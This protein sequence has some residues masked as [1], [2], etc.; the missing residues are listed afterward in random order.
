MKRFIKEPYRW[1]YF[2]SAGF[3]YLGCVLRSI[4]YYESV[5]LIQ[6]L[7]ILLI[8]LGLYVA[9]I[10]ITPNWHPF[11]YFYLFIQSVL[12]FV[13]TYIH[14]EPDF[15]CVLFAILGMQIMQAIKPG[16]GVFIIALFTPLT[17][18]S[19]TRV[20]GWDQILPLAFV[21]LA[22]NVLLSSYVY[23]AR[24]TTEA[25]A[26]NEHLMDELHSA[27]D[28]LQVYARELEQFSV[29]HERNRLP[30]ELHDSV[31]QTI[32][33]MTLTT[34]SARL[35]LKQDPSQVSV[36]LD[37]LNLLAH[38]AQKEMHQLISQ[39]TPMKNQRKSLAAQLKDHIDQQLIT[40]V[41]KVSMEVSGDK[42][43]KTNEE[44]SLFRIAQEAL[45]NII[46]HSHSKQATIRLHMDEPYW[47]DIE[48]QGQGF[49]P[50]HPAN[51]SGVGLASMR[52]R[53]EGIGWKFDIRS[54][55]NKG[56]IV[57]VEKRRRKRGSGN[58]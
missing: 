55:P 13:V 17:A 39:L 33:S 14:T 22:A 3:L 27:N 35:L 34:Q 26:R 32:F 58:G 42:V 56:T 4:I 5:D 30:R 53:A 19:L 47:M 37:R 6:V 38:N 24:R 20:Y 8:W 9:E 11:I 15:F 12:I 43:L 2:L 49:D 52:E 16:L 31:T 36:Q 18:L 23:L 44:Q 29:A 10:F 40:D 1:V 51:G 50:D 21:Y 48:D 41:I 45:N 28:Q 7:V 46:K 57:R 25:R 54:S